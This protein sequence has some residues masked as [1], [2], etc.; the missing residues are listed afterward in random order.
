MNKLLRFFRNCLVILGVLFILLVAIW[1]PEKLASY[2][3]KNMLNQIVSEQ[4]EE[5]SEG[6]QYSL[7]N[8]EKL[9]ILAECLSN[10]V[11]P[12]T[13]LSEKT[14][15]KNEVNYEGLNG[16][17]ALVT[18][19]QEPTEKEIPESEVFVAFNEQLVMLKQLGILPQEVKETGSASYSAD[20]YSAIDVL[21]PRNNIAVWKVSLST[22]QLNADKTNRVLDACLD[23]QTG[24]IYEFYVR[25]EMD[26]EELEPEKIVER[27]SDYLGL[28]GMSEYD[29]DNP[30]LET[31]PY[32]K[33]YL[34][35]GVGEE[36][37]IVTIG[38]YEG[39]NELFLK[40]T[41]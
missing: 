25:I 9:F 12:E 11:L 14:Q 33:K 8:N 23:A 1:G 2:R 34:F 32:F 21:E 5:T 17:Y 3:D 30:L 16:T 10:Q 6:Y 38:F 4:V 36:S 41:R 29:T 19:Y 26:W 20:L 37:T 15:V 7:S 24:K 22:S 18:N 27:W 39:I 35:P 31:T 13:E 28:E 40:I